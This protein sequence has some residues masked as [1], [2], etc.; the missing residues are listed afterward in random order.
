MQHKNS[1]SLRMTSR[2]DALKSDKRVTNNSKPAWSKQKPSVQSSATLFSVG[3]NSLSDY[4]NT[5]AEETTDKYV[6][7]AMRWREQKGRTRHNF[8]HNN[9]AQAKQSK[10]PI[11]D[12]SGASF[13]SMNGETKTV[14]QQSQNNTKYVEAAAMDDE[15]Y[16]TKQ[17]EIAEKT[18]NNTTYVSTDTLEENQVDNYSEE[19]YHDPKKPVCKYAAASSAMR[20]LRAYQYKRDEEN[21]VFGAQSKYWGMKSLLDF[22]IDSDDDSNYALSSDDDTEQKDEEVEDY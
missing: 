5:K 1:T 4:I 15:E 13:P 7:P 21:H 10:K 2:F 22:N 9:F 19:D 3:N 20:M 17:R 6:S 8:R 11:L 14:I 18:N 16:D 12:I